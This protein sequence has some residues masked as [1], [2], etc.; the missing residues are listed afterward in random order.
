[1]AH[2]ITTKRKSLMIYTKRTYTTKQVMARLRASIRGRM[3]GF[4]LNKPVGF[5]SEKKALNFMRKHLVS[6]QK[7]AL[8]LI[9]MK[10]N[11]TPGDWKYSRYSPKGFE[12]RKYKKHMKFGRLGE[13]LIG[14]DKT[15]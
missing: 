6:N 15:R 14:F 8:C 11:N 5:D 2:C 10:K 12:V 13:F 4:S 9:K 7:V 1:M 3:E